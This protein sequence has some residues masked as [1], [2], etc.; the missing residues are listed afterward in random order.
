VSEKRIFLKSRDVDRL[1]ESVE[2]DEVTYS[3][4]DLVDFEIS[5]EIRE[6]CGI[7]GIEPRLFG[8]IVR[9]SAEP[10][11]KEILSV[12]GEMKALLRDITEDHVKMLDEMEKL[13]SEIK[14]D[15][16]QL[17]RLLKYDIPE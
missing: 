2:A 16:H 17:A 3:S 14:L 5:S 4:I 11:M 13:Q 1:M 6:V 7:I 12:S 10:V 8:T 9:E 15:Y